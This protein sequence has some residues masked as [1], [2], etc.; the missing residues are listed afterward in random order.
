MANP[1]LSTKYG[2][3]LIEEMLNSPEVQKVIQHPTRVWVS[4]DQPSRGMFD[5]EYL[6]KSWLT[7]QIERY[8]RVYDTIEDYFRK[9]G[10]ILPA[11]PKDFLKW[12]V[13]KVIAKGD[14][15]FEQI[16]TVDFNL[17]HDEIL[18]TLNKKKKWDD[19]YKDLSENGYI[20]ST[21]EVFNYA[22]EFKQLPGGNEKIQWRTSKADAI[23]FQIGLGFKMPQ[24]NKCF[25]SKDERPFTLGSASKVNREEPLR[26]IIDKY[27]SQLESQ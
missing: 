19:L 4:S 22:M 3:R 11:E 20:Y 14:F 27:K 24:F 10:K 23:A 8:G 6:F 15:L 21:T 17:Y 2:E 26:S 12:F 13:N 9:E 5:E 25:R 1:N 16:E 7:G 18:K